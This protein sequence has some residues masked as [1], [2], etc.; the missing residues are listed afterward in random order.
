[1]SKHISFAYIH[2]FVDFTT[3]EEALEYIKEV[4]KKGG[5]VVPCGGREYITCLGEGYQ[6]PYSVEVNLKYKN[7]NGGW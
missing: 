3:E 2:K 6:Y 7:Y 5:Y 1:M 4:R